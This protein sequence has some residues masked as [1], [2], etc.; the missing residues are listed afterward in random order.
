MD[1]HEP[2]LGLSGPETWIQ[3]TH[4]ET[5]DRLCESENNPSILTSPPLPFQYAPHV[6]SLK[7]PLSLFL[8]HNYNLIKMQ[9]LLTTERREEEKEEEEEERRRRRGTF[10][11]E[12]QK[13]SS[14]WRQD[15]RRGRV[16]QE[17]GEWRRSGSV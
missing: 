15:E 7:L 10:Q 17:K 3:Q 8:D 13:D 4:K 1:K 9:E 11:T 16:N 5:K 14:R 2:V 6:L 12:V